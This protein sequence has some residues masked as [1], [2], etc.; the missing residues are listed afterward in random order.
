MTVCFFGTYDRGHS[1]NRLLANAVAA[2]GL[3]LE[4]LH[5]PLWETQASKDRRYFGVRSLGTL[6]RRYALAARGLKRRWQ[7]RT[8]PPPVVLVGFGGQLDVLLAHRVC[9]PRRALVFAPLV[10]LTETLVEDRRV[11]RAGGVQARALAALDRVTLRLPDLVLADTTAHARYLAALGA[12][13]ERVETW[14][15]GAE[16]EFLDAQPPRPTGDSVLYYGRFLP[17][18]G[19]ETIIAA[20]AKLGPRATVTLLGDGPERPGAERLAQALRAP[21]TWRPPLPLAELP[22]ELARAAVVLGVFGTGEKAAMVVPNK[23][24]QAAAIGRPL[25]TRDGPGLREVLEPEVHCVACPPGDAD[26]LAAAVARLLDDRSLAERLGH[27]AR[28]RIVGDFGPRLQAERIAR[29]LQ[30]RFGGVGDG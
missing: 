14:Y 18:H 24:Y 28:A 27:A 30:D 16:P 5:A 1:A 19:L 3:R 11:F 7:A 15:L 9:R 29:M 20:A 10:S 23:V 2:S 4:E 22:A 25:V 6:A 17:L 21:I 12:P 13:Q 26:A 8:G